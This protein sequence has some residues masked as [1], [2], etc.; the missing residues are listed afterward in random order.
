AT[1]RYVIEG[2]V[3][4]KEE[5]KKDLREIFV[6]PD[7]YVVTNSF[8]T[9]YELGGT[10]QRR[11]DFVNLPPKCTIHIFTASGKKVRTL[12]HESTVDYGRK[13]W[14]LTSDDGPEVAFGIYFFVVDAPDIGSKRGKFALIK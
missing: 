4:E 14:D 1:F 8:E 3:W 13:S 5:A 12:E 11:V 2:G 6:V 10:T 7:P 9:I